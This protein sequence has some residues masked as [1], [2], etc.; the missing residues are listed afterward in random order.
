MERT[1][2]YENFRDEK[3]FGAI[4][5]IIWDGDNTIWDWMKYAVEA[6]EAMALAIAEETGK[7]E[8]EVAAAMKKF[9]T[10]VGTIEDPGLIQDLTETGFFKDLPNFDQ[11]KLILKAQKAFTRERKKHLK[12]YQGVHEVIK[13]AYEHGIKN[14]ILTDAPAPQAA[15]RIKRSKINPYLTQVNAQPFRKTKDLPAKFQKREMRGVYN[16]DFDITEIPTEKPHTNLEEIL[17]M[18]REQIRKH[19][20]IIGDNDRKD[21]EL[22]RLYGCRG[23]HAVYGE[24][25]DA[26]LQRLL[27]FTPVRVAQRNVA[28]DQKTNGHTPQ[29]GQLITNQPPKGLIVKVDD[30]REIMKVLGIKP[31]RLW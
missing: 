27:R 21:M 17:Q 19:V 7:S 25:E 28:M 3:E 2:Q 9:Y 12:V 10:K 18:T 29:P 11:E 24:V 30:P 8:P 6:Y 23:I 4:T 1:E 16:V 26:V 31:K 5:D 14:R 15:M 20:V 22:V 13:T